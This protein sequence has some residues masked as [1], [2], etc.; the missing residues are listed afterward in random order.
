MCRKCRI[1]MSRNS[2]HH[3]SSLQLCDSRSSLLHE[4]RSGQP[5]R[6]WVCNGVGCNHWL[7]PV[8]SSSS[9]S[10]TTRPPLRLCLASLQDSFL[11]YTS[12]YSMSD[13]CLGLFRVSLLHKTR[14]TKTEATIAICSTASSWWVMCSVTFLPT[15]CSTSSVL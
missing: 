12:R 8:A 11:L 5:G 4:K 6:V 2:L 15:F 3:G 13:R 14:W 7:F 10:P 9:N 1:H